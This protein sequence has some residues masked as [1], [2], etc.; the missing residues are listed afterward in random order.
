MTPEKAAKSAANLLI[1][2]FKD[3]TR[4]DGSISAALQPHSTYLGPSEQRYLFRVDGAAAIKKAARNLVPLLDFYPIDKCIERLRA[5]V[6]AV[7]DAGTPLPDAHER[8]RQEVLQFLQ[9]FSRQGEWEVAYAVRGINPSECPFALGAC[10]FYIMD[11]NQFLLWGRRM[12]TG[13]Y[14]PPDNAPLFQSWLQQ[15][16]VLRG[17]VVATARVRATDHEHARAKGRNRIEEVLYVLRY[18]Q[19][20]IGFAESAFPEVGVSVQQWWED[21]SIV[22]QLDKP[23][24]GTSKKGGGHVGTPLSICCQAQG[25]NGLEQLVGLELSG[26]NELQLRMTTALEWIGQAA[27]APT[28]PIRLVALMT[29]LEALLIEEGETLGKKSKLANRVSRL[30]A[31]ASAEAQRVAQDMEELYEVRSECVHA[32]LVDVEKEEL[33]KAVRL[34]AAT[35]DVLLSRA[36]F[37]TMTSLAD[38]LKEIEHLS[39]DELRRRWIA[40]NAYFRWLGEGCPT[41]RDIQHWLEAEKDYSSLETRKC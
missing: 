20:V 10:R 32:G 36:P 41:G 40:V 9:A 16:S 27:V 24:F 30:I 11:N 29:A 35:V 33:T 19:L 21:H 4:D 3:A 37:C 17:Q 26:R 31:N 15:E 34:F 14:D 8:I 6:I 12:A 23:K 28:R 25:W 7:K 39:S 22:I 5:I 2:A 18:G 13:R 38:V 1:L